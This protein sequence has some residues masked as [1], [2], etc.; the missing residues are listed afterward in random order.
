MPALDGLP[1]ADENGLGEPP[2]LPVDISQEALRIARAIDRL[3]HRPGRYTITLTIPAS[4]RRPWLIEISRI[5][6]LQRLE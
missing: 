3:S 1:A 4:R 5:E 6:P 2:Q